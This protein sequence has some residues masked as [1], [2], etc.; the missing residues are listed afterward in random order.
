[1]PSEGL[2]KHI[3]MILDSGSGHGAATT[4]AS[5]TAYGQKKSMTDRTA[6]EEDPRIGAADWNNPKKRFDQGDSSFD[7]P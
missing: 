7:E 3:H 4:I 6:I 5:P 1:M 2:P